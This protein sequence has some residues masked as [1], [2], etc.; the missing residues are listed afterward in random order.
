MAVAA[1]TVTDSRESV[2]DFTTAFY[3]E[4]GGVLIKVMR[5]YR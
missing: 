4:S 1:L 5:S 2:V 3:E